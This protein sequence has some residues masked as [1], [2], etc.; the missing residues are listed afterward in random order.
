MQ[1]QT[2]PAKLKPYICK[3]ITNETS[4]KQQRMCRSE[5][6][7]KGKRIQANYPRLATILIIAAF[8]LQNYKW[9]L[10]KIII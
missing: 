9:K 6:P 10:L 3:S 2:R 7:N 8:F 4:K 5:L 1:S